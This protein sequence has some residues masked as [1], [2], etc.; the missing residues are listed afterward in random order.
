MEYPLTK[1][2]IYYF[3]HYINIEYELRE[4]TTRHQL[5]QNIYAKAVGFQNGR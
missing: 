5:N 1:P 2:D 4:N 3:R